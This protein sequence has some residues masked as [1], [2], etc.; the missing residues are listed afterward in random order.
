MYTYLVCAPVP[1]R[2]KRGTENGTQPRIVCFPCVTG[3]ENTYV[4]LSE[5]FWLVAQFWLTGRCVERHLEGNHKLYSDW[6]MSCW[7]L[8]ACNHILD[9]SNHQSLQNLKEKNR[10]CF[11]SV[12]KFC[13]RNCFHRWCKEWIRQQPWCRRREHR[14]KLRLTILRRPWKSLQLQEERWLRRTSS[15]QAF[16][17]WRLRPS[18]GR[19]KNK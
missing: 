2:T 9:W 3:K 15:N 1:Q 11:T 8:H 7:E 12:S 10:S 19:P 13:D 14:W 4:I 5:S 18:T 6:P 17:G 16:V